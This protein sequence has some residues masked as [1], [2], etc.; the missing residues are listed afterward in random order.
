MTHPT[1]VISLFLCI[2]DYRF[3]YIATIFMM[4]EGCIFDYS[5]FF[6]QNN[7]VKKFKDKIRGFEGRLTPVDSELIQEY[8]KTLIEV[9][10]GRYHKYLPSKIVVYRQPRFYLNYYTFPIYPRTTYVFVK[11]T[12]DE[13]EAI[14]RA[15]FAHELGHAFHAKFRTHKY[16]MTTSVIILQT[17][18]IML[19]L[20][21]KC[22]LLC[23][24]TLIAN[25]VLFYV[26]Y[27]EY[28]VNLE[29]E[30]DFAALKIIERIEGNDA[31][32]A[33]AV[34]LLKM[35]FEEYNKGTLNKNNFGI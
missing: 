21:Q 23:L 4:L 27:V 34:N 18:M 6:L 32:K 12:F 3:L 24:I 35:R 9:D 11:N 14:D 26:N 5:Y 31:M 1:S 28:E 8:C 2:L 13:S 20:M 25:F 16:S 7:S 10:A 19:S 29:T 22:W 30:A 15:V 33:A 17:V